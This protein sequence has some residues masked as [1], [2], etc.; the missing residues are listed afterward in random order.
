MLRM[1]TKPNYPTNIVLVGFLLISIEYELEPLYIHLESKI[2]FLHTEH[3]SF[4]CLSF[5]YQV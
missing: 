2:L 1:R 3:L 5:L 4:R